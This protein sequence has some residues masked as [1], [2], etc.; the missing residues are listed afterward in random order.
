MRLVALSTLLIAAAI[1]PA[2]AAAKH[3]TPITQHTSCAT[4]YGDRDCHACKNCHYCRNCNSGG[5]LCGVYYAANGLTPPWEGR[6]SST[7][8][9][10]HR[11][12]RHH[13]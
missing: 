3:H 10:K 1:S 4:C 13:K 9:A 8:P 7:T 6:G 2:T 11:K 12:R 5:T